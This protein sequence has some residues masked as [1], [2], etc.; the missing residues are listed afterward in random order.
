MYLARVGAERVLASV[1]NA[2]F[3]AKRSADRPGLDVPRGDALKGDGPR[4][5]LDVDIAGRIGN[6][7]LTRDAG[8]ID[9]PVGALHL[10]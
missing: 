3:E 5:G 9:I 8:D 10:Y 7:Y 1:Q 4:G 6:G 2:P